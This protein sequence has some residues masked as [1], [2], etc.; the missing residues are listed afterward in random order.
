MVQ[1]GG[2]ITTHDE[3][4]KAAE[5]AARAAGAAGRSSGVRLYSQRPY[6]RR[7]KHVLHAA[8]Q[9]SYSVRSYV[10]T[11]VKSKLWD[12]LCL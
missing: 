2:R 12:I 7:H 6:Q 3:C 4:R 11:L 10:L 8:F 5:D 1:Q 9:R